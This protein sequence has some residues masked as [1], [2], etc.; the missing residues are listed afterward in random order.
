MK[1]KIK[2]L[3][4]A[5]L[6]L[7]LA[8]CVSAPVRTGGSGTLATGAAAGASGSNVTEGLERCEQPFGTIA[9]IEDRGSDWYQIL[10]NQYRL[11]S[12]VPVLRLL[13]QQSNCFIV[14]D[15]GRGMSMMEQERALARSGELRAGSNFG[16]GQ[17]ASADYSIA[18]EVLF[19]ERG[20]G[21][22]GAA[23][24]VVGGS[25]VGALMGSLRTNEAAT[26]LTL[27]DNRSGVQV[28]V[29]EGS[30]RNTDMGFGGLLGGGGAVG[31]MGGYTNT[32]QGK[33]ISGAF[34]HS[35]NQLVASLRNYQAQT[36]GDR[37]LGTGG[38]LQVDGAT[39]PAGYSGGR[40][41]LRQAQQIL[42]NMGYDA[43]PVDGAM[44]PR[45]ARALREFQAER[46]IPVTGRL[47]M[48]TQAELMR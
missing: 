14:V 40:V 38:R 47:D 12:T 10:T 32:P 28:A 4:V 48:T 19:S 17:M 27:V 20:T 16:S 34:M 1:R 7:T 43:G 8:G 44:G 33:V 36:M 24:G 6:S 41:N 11:T 31:G 23:A 13:I 9:V 22:L 39:Q 18:P 46:G 45:T 15:R 25:L 37:G 2:F 42:N 3:M 35:Y 5:C 26:L 29:A 30:A 21:G